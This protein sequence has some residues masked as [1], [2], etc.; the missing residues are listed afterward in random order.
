M[1]KNIGRFPKIKAF[2]WTLSSRNIQDKVLEI[3]INSGF[4]KQNIILY[5]INI[6]KQKTI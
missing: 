5:Q 1:E 3:L 6:I 4:E 2:L